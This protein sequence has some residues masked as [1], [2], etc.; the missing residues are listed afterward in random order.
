MKLY[1]LERG[2]KFKI[3]SDYQTTVPIGALEVNNATVYR[4]H[5][6]DGMSSYCTSEDGTVYHIPANEEIEVKQ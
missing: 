5:N 4:L 3:V 2:T 6:I 1:E